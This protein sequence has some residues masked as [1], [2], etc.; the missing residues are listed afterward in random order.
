M[1][2]TWFNNHV[3]VILQ[4]DVDTLWKIKEPSYGFKR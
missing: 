2:A 4:K 3:E 1:T